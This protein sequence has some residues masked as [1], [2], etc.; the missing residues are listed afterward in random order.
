MAPVGF[1]NAGDRRDWYLATGSL[2]KMYATIGE[3]SSYA[4]EQLEAGGHRTTGGQK[5]WEDGFD[6]GKHASRARYWSDN[7]DR[8]GIVFVLRKKQNGRTQLVVFDPLY[9]QWEP[10]PGQVESGVT[11]W[12]RHISQ[13]IGKVVKYSERWHGG[14]RSTAFDFLQIGADDSMKQGMAFLWDVINDRLPE[15]GLQAWGFGYEALGAN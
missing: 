11:T 12:K 8:C 4:K 2:S 7:C 14:V 15:E 10:A 3:F 1:L 13:E 9:A 5:R 6:P